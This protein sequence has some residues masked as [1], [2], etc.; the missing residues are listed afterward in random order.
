M[1]RQV[2]DE[3][4]AAYTDT[5]IDP[6]GCAFTNYCSGRVFVSVTKAF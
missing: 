6:Q 2:G 4:M 5:S 3:V 1:D